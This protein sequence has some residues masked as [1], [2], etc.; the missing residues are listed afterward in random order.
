MDPR[1]ALK[2]YIKMQLKHQIGLAKVRSAQQDLTISEF[3]SKSTFSTLEQIK[4]DRAIE[5]L[6]EAHPEAE[7]YYR[8]LLGEARAELEAEEG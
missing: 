1:I 7:A 8:S 3:L 6:M 4:A 5:E 2:H